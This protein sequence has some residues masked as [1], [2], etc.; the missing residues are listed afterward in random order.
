MSDERKFEC[1]YCDDPCVLIMYGMGVRD[2]E[3]ITPICCPYDGT[4]LKNTRSGWKEVK[5]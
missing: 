4:R 1:N 2:D 5:E 3:D